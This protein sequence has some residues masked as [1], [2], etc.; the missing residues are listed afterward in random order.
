MIEKSNLIKRKKFW[1][2]KLKTKKGSK[3]FPIFDGAKYF[4]E[5]DAE[6]GAEVNV[7]RENG[8]IKKVTIKGKPEKIPQAETKKTVGGDKIKS[9]ANHPQNTQTTPKDTNKMQQALPEVLG[10]PFHNPYTFI[11]FMDIPVT[12]KIAHIPLSADDKPN[13]G[14]HTGIIRLKVQTKSPLMSRDSGKANKE[15]HK[16]YQMLKIGRNVVVPATAIK[17]FL[18]NLTTLLSGGPLHNLDENAYLCQGRD[19]QIQGENGNA[20]FL[21]CVVEPGDVLRDGTLQLGESRFISTLALARYEDKG[22]GNKAELDR[23]EQAMKEYEDLKVGRKSARVANDKNLVTK[24]TKQMERIKRNHLNMVNAAEKLIESLRKESRPIWILPNKDQVNDISYDAPRSEDYW[25]L[26]ISGRPIQGFNKKEGL[27]KPNGQKIT[28]PSKLWAEY[29][30]RNMHGTQKTLQKNDL[31]W[32]EVNKNCETIQILSLQWARWGKKGNSVLEIIKQAHVKPDWLSGGKE[33]HPVT[34]MF[35]LGSPSPKHRDG[36]SVASKLSFDNLVFNRNV[37]I[38]PCKPIAPLSSPHPGCLGF[39]R[40]NPNPKSVSS[41]DYLKGYKVYRTTKEE[42]KVGPWNYYNVQPIYKRGGRELERA[43]DR[44]NVFS[45]ELLAPGAEGNLEITFRSLTKDELSLLMAACS[46]PWRLGGGKPLGLGLCHVTVSEVIDE[47]GETIEYDK[48]P[49]TCKFVDK[50]QRGYWIASQEPVDKLRYPRAAITNRKTTRGG[51][52]WFSKMVKPKQNLDKSSFTGLSPIY[53][54]DELKTK[55]DN[56]IKS[57][58]THNEHEH[59]A[60]TPI[61]GS[62]L[63][64]LNPDNPSA[65]Q[66]YGYDIH[67]EDNKRKKEYFNTN[68]ST[69]CYTALKKFSDE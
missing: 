24:L 39:Y 34:N 49:E 65:D 56:N 19:V 31:V 63:P 50:I 54:T 61:S 16:S 35:G 30:S 36:L 8:Q 52:N 51:H 3:E 45:S 21:A 32:L 20:P 22:G 5:E 41:N 46:V 26:K 15:K 17:G 27:F 38:F 6:E 10:E 42:G 2:V 25:Q 60:A 14:F 11:P 12:K 68:R 28:I 7:I 64:K 44:E 58:E 13:K 29:A 48:T 59:A 40:D 43:Q 37:K 57:H 67:F 1:Q 47:F 62:V 53:S 4:R 18:R 69:R 66:L 55:A 23:L 33:I 9:M